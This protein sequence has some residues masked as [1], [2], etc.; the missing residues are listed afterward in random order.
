MAKVRQDYTDLAKQQA[1]RKIA[2][3]RPST[4]GTY[5][6][7][8]NGT[9]LGLATTQLSTIR[10]EPVRWLVPGYLPL[11]K[12][13]LLAGDGGHGKSAFTLRLAADVSRGRPCLGL[14]YADALMG[15]VLLVSCEDD[16]AD[17]VIPRLLSAGAD[18]PKIHR[19]DGVQAADGK[20]TPFSLAHY[21]A[22]AAEL[23]KRPAVRLIAVDPA[24][25]YIGRTGVD[26][27]KD[28]ELRSL[29]DPLAKLAADH[30]V[31]VLL[32]KHLSKG[33]TVKAIH[34]V[35]GSA[36]YVNSV[37]AAFIVVPDADDQDRKLF[38]PLKFN[39]ARKPAGLVYRTESLDDADCSYIL[40][41]HA[42]HLDDADRQRLAS[43]LFRV[44]WDGTTEVD[45][46]TAVSAATKSGD[47]GSKVDAAMVW[48]REYLAEY[49]R[50]SDDVIG[51]GRDAGFSRDTL[52]KARKK[53]NGQVESSNLGLPHWYWGLGPRNEWRVKP[54]P[55]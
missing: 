13:V 14:N 18:L 19:V 26:D 52:F 47:G 9:P 11:G 43:Q 33:A 7:S 25:S 51:A 12:L 21:D 37:R 46:D 3:E 22:I 36:G 53:M 27:H 23:T 8:T 24:G 20:P 30:R 38:L 35:S 55:N 50:S 41:K 5:H 6:H 45:A 17:T 54:S 4:T 2:A 42:G 28:S 39:I 16:Y 49:A 32:V 48:L 29:L 31:T 10:P 40:E 44:A 34:K 15:E 1:R